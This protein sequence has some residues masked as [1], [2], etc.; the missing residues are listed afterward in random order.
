MDSPPTS[1]PPIRLLDAAGLACNAPREW[2]PH[3]VEVDVPASEWESA[4]LR[5]NGQP[6]PL[7]LR[8]L[9]GAVRVVAEW[10]RSGTGSY[11]LALRAPRGEYRRVVTVYPEK[12]PPATVARLL[13]DL[14]L[15][16]PAAIAIALQQAGGLAGV[17]LLPPE[18]STVSE[19]LLRLR[20]AV[21]GTPQRAGLA[22]ALAEISRDPHQVLHARELWVRR[23][24][25]RQPHPARLVQALAR[26]G[27]LGVDLR[28]E[29]VLDTR[30][31][32]STDV[33]ENRLVR[34]FVEQVQQRL[35]RLAR[36]PASASS[37]GVQSTVAVLARRM[38]A[39]R[40]EA[41]FLD[42]VVA[43]EHAPQR[44]T[45][46]LLRRPGYRAALE[47]L[48]EFQRS[49]A[50][51][52]DAPALDA[53]L[54]NAPAL[55]QLWG[56]LQVIHALLVVA[57]EL[58]YRVEEEHLVRR[59][60]GA[61]FLRVL[62]DGRPAVLLRHPVTGVSVRLLPERA[63]RRQGAQLGLWST[64]YEQRPDVAVEVHPPDGATSVYLFDPKYKLD[65]EPLESAGGAG[66]PKKVDIDKM[67]A[68]RDAIRD[69]E[70]RRAVRYAAILYP[71]PEQRFPYGVEAL[72][73]YPG[74]A[75][76]LVDRLQ[77]V[78]REALR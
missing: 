32:H 35:R 22:D 65:G 78:L 27:N 14:E 41:A 68:Y 73:A 29:R 18:L 57:A 17:E 23:A 48:L 12:L 46:V 39:A 5:R 52:L 19:E 25:A 10:P 45:M 66:K 55:Y 75:L 54:E 40:R 53:P 58:G 31:E 69:R 37:V 13:E 61:A 30:V 15:H 28:P 33:Y 60:P 20:R 36:L 64:T 77:E 67:H 11:A 49:V 76:P 8:R 1:E 16:L 62:P 3:W 44:V 50:V 38:A 26:P 63:Y 7:A 43:L 24:A 21:E 59:A 56:T 71:G 42:G 2:Q 9:A 74:S 34:T 47:G 51:Q 4:E 70:G 72:T 6:L